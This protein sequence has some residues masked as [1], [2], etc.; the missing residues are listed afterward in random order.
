MLSGLKKPTNVRFASDGRIFVTE[1]SGIIKVFRFTR[2]HRAR[3]VRRPYDQRHGPVGSRSPGDRAYPGFP[4][5]PYVYV[6]YTYDAPP[7]RAA[8]VWHDACDDPVGMGCPVTARLSRLEIGP[9]NTAVSAEKVLL[10]NTW[11][12]QFPS[13]SIGDLAFGPDGA[14]YASAGDG[15]NFNLQDYGKDWAESL[16]GSIRH[17][18]RASIAERAHR[19]SAH[20][21]RWGD[22]ACRSGDRP[23]ALPSNPLYGGVPDDDRIIAFGLRNPFRFNFRPGTSEIWIA[24]VG[25]DTTEEINRIANASDAIVENF[26][27][28]CYEG[29]AQAPGYST[30][31][32]CAGLYSSAASVGVVTG[33]YF[34]YQHGAP[35]GPPCNDCSGASI[36]GVTFYSGTSYPE[37]YRGSLFFSD[38]AR[39][40]IWTMLKERAQIPIRRGWTVNDAAP[41]PVSLQIG[42]GGDVFYVN[43]GGDLGGVT[44][45]G[46]SHPPTRFPSQLPPPTWRT[47]V[48]RSRCTSARQSRPILKAVSPVTRG[49]WTATGG[50]A[51]RP[52]SARRSLTPS[53]ASTGYS[54]GSPTAPA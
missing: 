46:S 3:G 5:K 38:Y 1:K 22:P 21:D 44:S 30:L 28:P 52:T 10:E 49:I 20:V 36:T 19:W 37:A 25:W 11:C 13:H 16:L 43:H 40:Q 29:A 24:D 12:A 8:P 6:L 27:W 17:G 15:A 23:A 54:Y 41:D 47:D 26:G 39:R 32:L 18:R 51:T 4:A 7:G 2:R 48:H 50:S 34:A 53:R 14:L 45:E 35:P 9:A 42:P 33:P 31:P